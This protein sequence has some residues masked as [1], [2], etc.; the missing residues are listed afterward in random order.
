MPPR[1]RLTHFND[2]GEARMVDVGGKEATERKAV[3]EGWI[4]MRAETLALIQNGEHQ[5]G[6]VLAVA[7][8]A[9]I[10]AAKRTAE[11]VPLCHPIMLTRISVELEVD[12][13][14]NR[15]RCVATTGT[16]ERTGVEMEA[17]SAVQTALLTIYDMC[18]AADR[19]MEIRNVR[20]VHKSGGKSG[21]WNRGQMPRLNEN[22]AI[23][24]AL[25]LKVD[26]VAGKKVVC[27]MCNDFEFQMWP[28]GWD[29]HAASRCA[30]LSATEA[31]ARK[32][33]YKRATTHLFR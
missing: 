18:K 24:N 2:R 14:D 6:D 22:G 9:G 28:E 5:K 8:V 3:A 26:D 30:G 16:T 4:N 12:N 20:L 29:A 10:M 1:D 17:L 11:L 33:E 19:G 31:Q 32:D 21:Q 7:R 13:R 27:P 23:S 25:D 15:V